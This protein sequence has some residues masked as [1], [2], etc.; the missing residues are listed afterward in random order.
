MNIAELYTLYKQRPAVTTDSRAC[1]PG[2]L[3]FALRGES[4]D[5]NAYAEKALQAGC[6]HA[7]IDDA[8]AW[9]GERT[10][11]VDNALETLQQLARLHRRTLGVTVIGIT[12]TNGKTTTK[13]L[14]AKVLSQ[15]Y[16]VLFTEGNLNNHIGVP[17]T[18]LR[19]TGRHEIA[20]VEMGANHPGEIR[21]LA[22]IA[23]P[24]YGLITNVGYAH[25]E[26]FGS[27]EGVVRAKGELYDFLRRTDGRIFIDGDNR[28]L[29]EMAEG[30]EKTVYGKIPDVSPRRS[31]AGNVSGG[32]AP[33]VTGKVTHNYPFLSFRWQTPGAASPDV[34]A[35][36]VETRLVGDYNLGNA[37]AAIAAGLHFHVPPGLIN[38]AISAYEPA[39][40]RSQ[41]K[42]TAGNTLVIDA[43]NANP[44][45]MRAA[46]ENF[47]SAES[48]PG[49]TP[50]PEE[51]KE[52]SGTTF[53]RGDSAPLRKAVILG[54]MLE[55]G[56]RSP[57]LHGEIIALVKKCGFDS[58]L[59]CGEQFSAAGQTFTC[60]RD[61]DG[62]NEYLEAN[63]PRGCEILI[64][65]SRGMHLEKI[66][67]NL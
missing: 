19:L 61:V 7:V 64:K 52:L 59:L 42:K 53:S 65:G 63:P 1:P 15:K 66:I 17:L 35:Y 54:D 39:N 27:F 48:R 2:A 28:Y 24:D 49:R 13:E 10:I 6:S 56:E 33:S 62:L 20:V 31:D 14:M 58:V 44:S 23:L 38:G 50:P 47:A 12:G 55:L 37:L 34:E 4:S 57:E 30:I 43:Y 29:T 67:H 11:L 32:K 8:A 51:E 60:F 16:S 25:L 22:E 5:G 18:L 40:S 21:D 26:G 3:F 45:S 46:L 36:D 41:R 9:A